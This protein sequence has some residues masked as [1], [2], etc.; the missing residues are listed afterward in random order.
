[1]KSFTYSRVTSNAQALRP[2]ELGVPA[3]S[4]AEQI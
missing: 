3:S 4:L 1:M 2:L